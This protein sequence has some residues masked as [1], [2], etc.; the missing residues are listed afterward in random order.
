V[1]QPLERVVR[2]VLELVQVVRRL[3]PVVDLEGDPARAPVVVAHDGPAAAR[4]HRLDVP[5]DLAAA[6][7]GRVGVEQQHEVVEVRHGGAR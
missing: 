2:L 1:V 4:D 6:L 3:G 7:L 5:E